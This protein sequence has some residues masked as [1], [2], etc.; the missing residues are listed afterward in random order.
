LTRCAQV[1]FSPFGPLAIQVTDGSR[2]FAKKHFG[3][4]RNTLPELKI[5]IVSEW[6]NQKISGFRGGLVL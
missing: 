3:I 1:I 2:H 5:E 6:Y 4:S